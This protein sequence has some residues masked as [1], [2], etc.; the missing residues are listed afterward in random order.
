[1]SDKQQTKTSK[2]AHVMSLLNKG[3][4]DHAGAA[5]GAAQA[6][7]EQH[8]QAL[9]LA[10]PADVDTAIAE[11]IK[12]ALNEDWE[13]A[14][15]KE[16]VGQMGEMR[17]EAAER[18]EPVPAEE[19]LSPQQSI[20]AAAEE[21]VL[22]ERP[23]PQ[24]AEEKAEEPIEYVN[25][26]QVLVEEKAEKYIKMF[27]LCQCPRCV[28]DVKALALCNLP[29]KYVVMGKGERIPR[30][31]IYESRYNTAVTAQIMRA[32]KIVM[33]NPRHDLER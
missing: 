4:Q 21:S 26:M 27:E 8:G 19:Q 6:D 17:T 18:A 11:Q 28:V 22:P 12:N 13:S 25:V 1:M 15:G 9:T 5:A 33:E 23:E 3:R 14:E 10:D 20:Q 2:T 7:G 24:A 32:C 29:A 16:A 31:T 30:I